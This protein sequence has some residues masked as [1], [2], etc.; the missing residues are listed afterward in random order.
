M[1]V[2]CWHCGTQNPDGTA[3]CVNC[4]E[5]VGVPATRQLGGQ[6]PSST[7]V[8]PVVIASPPVPLASPGV[9]TPPLEPAAW[10]VLPEEPTGVVGGRLVPSTLLNPS[11][12]GKHPPAGLIA[13]IIAVVVAVLV[14]FGTF[15]SMR[16]D[17]SQGPVVAALPPAVEVV[18]GEAAW[19]VSV[20]PVDG[21]DAYS[22]GTTVEVTKTLADGTFVGSV[23]LSADG[24]GESTLQEYADAM[25][26]RLEEDPPVDFG[27]P[28]QTMVNGY[29]ALAY[30][31]KNTDSVYRYVFIA[32]PT[33]QWIYTFAA[34]A[35]SASTED[36][37]ADIQTMLDSFQI[38]Y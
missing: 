34:K 8:P 15:E 13:A 19:E 12:P 7:P 3:L 16:S 33:G 31:G 11:P 6:T 23:T 27:T 38:S 24:P 2:F 22:D 14:A 9:A 37:L 35:N 30:V 5:A 32:D 4:G 17:T 29:A 18:W 36:P 21:W 10:D 28:A 26:G 20:V 25:L 1:A